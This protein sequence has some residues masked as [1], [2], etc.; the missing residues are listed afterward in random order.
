M[1]S[2]SV[3]LASLV[4]FSAPAV[5]APSPSSSV[6]LSSKIIGQL[7]DGTWLENLAVR[8]N[9]DILTTLL[10]P[11][12]AIYTIRQSPQGLHGLELLAN[13]SSVNSLGGIS[14][15]AVA[16]GLETYVVVGANTTGLSQPIRG[17]FSAWTVT[18]Q[19]TKSGVTREQVRIN[20]VSDMS[21]NST[22]LNGVISIPDVPHA[23]LVSDSAAGSVGY[24]D[25]QTGELDPDAFV[26][27]E[28]QPV[29][30]GAFPLGIDGIRI[31]DGYLYWTNT[32]R[33]VIY[34]VALA[35]S[36]YPATGATAEIVAN[37]TS[38]A[39]GLDDFAFD[40]RGNILAA[41]NFDN[42]V[43]YVDTRTGDAKTILGG[44]DDITFA[45]C[46]GVYFGRGWTEPN[47]FFVSTSGGLANPV[48]GNRTA[49]AS[50]VSVVA[51]RTL[52]S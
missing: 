6:S 40:S 24:L 37:L 35:A 21:P 25:I 23:V 8:P 2:L 1:Q 22:F 52:C 15:V 29:Q 27:P 20:K 39:H 38:L 50:I 4:A 49:G 30:G 31:H 48:G 3:L 16:S 14:P 34:R 32:L 43:L 13:F 41:T 12:G 46:T 7:P 18:F 26:F 45:G 44:E 33:V 36:G 51:S 10:F 28:M 11:Y 5:A 42:S 19:P 17:T 47:T 9:G